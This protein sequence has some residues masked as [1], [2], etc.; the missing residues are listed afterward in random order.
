MPTAVVDTGHG[1]SVTLGTTGGTWKVTEFSPNLKLTRPIV[2]STYMATTTNRASFPGDLNALGPITLTFLFQGTQG[3][4][5]TGVVETITITFPIPGGGAVTAGN[6]AGTAF[7]FD[8]EYPP[9]MTN[10]IQKG[11]IS[12]QYDGTTGPTYTATA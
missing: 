6:I 12:F 5:A 3:V 10:E 11:K 8:C 1:A 4:P 9:L 2:D 7:I